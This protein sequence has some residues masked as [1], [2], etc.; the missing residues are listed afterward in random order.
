MFEE[1]LIYSD[2]D[3]ILN[4]LNKKIV[5]KCKCGSYMNIYDNKHYKSCI[6]C[7]IKNN[8]YKKKENKSLE[9]NSDARN[10]IGIK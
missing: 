9:Y 3:N 5:F 7:A 4:A 10:W 6:D 8:K 1:N 2:H